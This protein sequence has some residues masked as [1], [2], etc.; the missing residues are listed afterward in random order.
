MTAGHSIAK[1]DS[2]NNTWMSNYDVNKLMISILTNDDN[3]I[4]R[5]GETCKY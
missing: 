4:I 3:S 2:E 5:D 1:R